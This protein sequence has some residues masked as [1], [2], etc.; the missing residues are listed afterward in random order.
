MSEEKNKVLSRK[1]RIHE[2]MFEADTYEGKAFDVALLLAILV[3]VIVVMLETTD[4]V[5]DKIG[6]FLHT[7]EWILTI[8]FTIE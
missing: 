7:V 5:A 1:D 6:G 2:I 4:S 8:F 3:S